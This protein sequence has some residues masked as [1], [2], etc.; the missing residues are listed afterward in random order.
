MIHGCLIVI[1]KKVS[2]R[3]SVLLPNEETLGSQLIKRTTIDCLL[4][5]ILHL[6]CGFSSDEPVSTK[7]RHFSKP[8]HGCQLERRMLPRLFI[9]SILSPVLSDKPS[10]KAT[11]AL[12]R[13]L[14]L[15]SNLTSNKEEVDWL[16]LPLL[17]GAPRCDPA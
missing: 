7:K 6:R 11:K 17:R 10:N 9:V 14:Q 13:S 5:S 4:H 8:S 15:H 2:I 16:Q 1:L 3:D 12:T